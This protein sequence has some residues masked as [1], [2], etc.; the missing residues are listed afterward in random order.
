MLE[1]SIQPINDDYFHR[2]SICFKMAEDC[3]ENEY[4]VAE[5]TRLQVKEEYEHLELQLT[6]QQW[7]F[8]PFT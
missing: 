2:N 1:F 5:I 8:K 7:R 4:N 6:M 3:T